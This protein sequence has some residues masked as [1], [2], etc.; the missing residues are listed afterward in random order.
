M[1]GDVGLV[2]DEGDW[3]GSGA[4][5]ADAGERERCEEEDEGLGA[6]LRLGTGGGIGRRTCK[7]EDLAGRGGGTS[8][9]IVYRVSS[10]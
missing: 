3:S 2:M 8:E 1:A 7:E 4:L 10:G 9:S 5:F 6:G